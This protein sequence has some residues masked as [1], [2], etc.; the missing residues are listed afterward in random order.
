MGVNSALGLFVFN[1]FFVFLSFLILKLVALDQFI[2]LEFVASTILFSHLFAFTENI[3]YLLS[4][5]PLLH[6]LRR[7]YGASGVKTQLWNIHTWIFRNSF[8]PIARLRLI[9]VVQERH[10]RFVWIFRF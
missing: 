4:F 2:E 1:F 6:F 8:Q 9:L 3:D 10:E 5:V 7:I